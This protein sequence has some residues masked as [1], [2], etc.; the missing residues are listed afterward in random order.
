MNILIAGC[1]GIGNIMS[2]TMAS[3]GAKN[4]LLLD[5]DVVEILD[6]ENFKFDDDDDI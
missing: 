5:D 3:L 4:L 6:L 2:Y 1:G